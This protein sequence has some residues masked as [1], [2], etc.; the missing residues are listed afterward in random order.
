MA[1]CRRI[2]GPLSGEPRSLEGSGDSTGCDRRVKPPSR[3]AMGWGLRGLQRRHT[4]WPETLLSVRSRGHL[5]QAPGGRESKATG[6]RRPAPQIPCIAPSLVMQSA[7][8][9]DSCEHL[10]PLEP[11]QRSLLLQQLAACAERAQSHTLVA[12]ESLQLHLSRDTRRERQ[13]QPR[14]RSAQHNNTTYK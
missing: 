14:R 6:G 1:C 7:G 3:G 4:G 10:A 8:H 12:V 13:T 9:R 11:G 5:P 2:R